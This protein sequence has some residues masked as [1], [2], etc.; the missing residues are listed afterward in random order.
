M[1]IYAHTFVSTRYYVTIQQATH[2]EREIIDLIVKHSND[3]TN[4]AIKLFEDEYVSALSQQPAECAEM[5]SIALL[6]SSN[7]NYIEY[8]VV[9]ESDYAEGA[10]D[11][12]WN[13]IAVVDAYL[14]RQIERHQ[15]P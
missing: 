11:N 12:G 13:L 4:A 10:Y 8:A 2:R 7:G 1:Y 5:Y 14:I 15:T 3:I 9:P 6:S